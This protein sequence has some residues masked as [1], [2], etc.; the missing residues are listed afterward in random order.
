MRAFRFL[1]PK[2][3]RRFFR[4]REHE[5]FGHLDPRKYTPLISTAPSRACTR[6]PAEP[7]YRAVC[8]IM[9]LLLMVVGVAPN[10]KGT[11]G[12]LDLPAETAMLLLEKGL[13]IEPKTGNN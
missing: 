7:I 13:F 2:N 6:S 5:G 3:E 9:H 11:Y 1:K 8:K 12:K 4:N 10:Q